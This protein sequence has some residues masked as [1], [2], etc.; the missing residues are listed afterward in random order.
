MEQGRT[1]TLGEGERR[2]M[3]ARM[4]ASV[5]G[6][7]SWEGH[8]APSRPRQ[9]GR[10]RARNGRDAVLRRNRRTG[11]ARRLLVPLLFELPARVSFPTAFCVA[12]AAWSTALVLA[13]GCF[14]VVG[15]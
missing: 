5:A 14:G 2:E 1:R 3:S 9:G 10:E 11:R 13:L 4:L 6:G 15:Q 12:T 7:P 8:A